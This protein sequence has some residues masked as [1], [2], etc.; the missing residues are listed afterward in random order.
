MRIGIHLE[1]ASGAPRR[2]PPPASRRSMRGEIQQDLAAFARVALGE[3]ERARD[4]AKIERVRDDVL[5]MHAPVGDP[6]DDLREHRAV[7][8]RRA[9]RQFLLRQLGLHDRRRLRREAEHTD[10]RGGRREPHRLLEDRRMADRVEDQR[11]AAVDAASL[12]RV[13]HRF[14]RRVDDFVGRRAALARER[15]TLV[16]A[17]GDERA[18]AVDVLEHLQQ[19]EA[20]GARAVDQ[21]DV[22]RQ[23]AGA[24]GRV[25][26]DRERLDDRSARVGDLGRN[27]VGVRGGHAGVLAEAAV[28]MH[29]E[30]G[31][32][33]AHVAPAD[34]ACV[35]APATDDRVDCDDLADAR[36]V[37]ARADRFDSPDELVPDDA[38]IRD[39]RVLA[40][41]DVQIRSADARI[42]HAHAHFARGGLGRGHFAHA[43][44]MRL[45]DDDAQHVLILLRVS[46]RRWGGARSPVPHRAVAQAGDG[47][48]GALVRIVR[49]ER[50][51]DVDAE[52]GHVVHHEIAVVEAIVVREHLVGQR[53]VRHQLLDAEVRRPQSEV[54]RGRHAHGRQVGR[55]VK[56]RADLVHRRVIGD[57]AHVRDAARVHDRRADVVDQLIAD[58]VL[59]IPDRIEDLADRERRRRVAADQ[60]ECVLVL[61]GRRVLEPEQPV[62]LEI[63]AEARRLDRREP[64]MRV[65][66]QVRRV[67]ERVAHLAEQLGRMAQV[68]RGVPRLLGR[69][70]FFGGLVRAR[71]LADAV[72]LRQPRHA[73]LHADRAVARGDVPVRGVDR[74]VVIA[75]VRVAIDHQPFAALA[76]EQLIDGHAGELALDVPERHVDRGDRRHRHGPAPPVR[77]AIQVLPDVLDVARVPADQARE[78]VILQIRAHRELAPVERRVAEAVDAFVGDDLDRHEIP[79]GAGDDDVQPFDFHAVSPVRGSVDKVVG[80]ALAHLGQV[81]VHAVDVHRDRCAEQRHVARRDVREDLLVLVQRAARVVFDAIEQQPA[82]AVE[83]PFHRLQHGPHVRAAG[84]FEHPAVHRL[85]EREERVDVVRGHRVALRVDE[86]GELRELRRRDLL[87]EIDVVRAFERAAREAA[88]L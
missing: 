37:D 12:E 52:A 64:V 39:E 9:Q 18:N 73:R 47:Q 20:D 82:H 15:E 58:Q 7:Q 42:A 79:A 4:I 71:R 32:A 14:R 27:P 10:A 69:Q 81:G 66:Q 36:R 86:A 49:G 34:R 77:A 83:L 50:L 5:R 38:R 1:A 72:H 62:R 29:A 31:Q 40:V 56:A 46:S 76:A 61:G 48:V 2:A 44:A 19:R 28:A 60:P 84:E 8:A 6:F 63:A 23:H 24:R 11:R 13:R 80:R 33:A 65:V 26:G 70:A 74:L 85:V 45:V 22:G 55:A 78:H 21:R 54:H 53:R 30:H 51:V 67:A 87:R 41:E 16:E 59:A 3:L 68:E 57:A 88:F 75:P 35:A 17:I 25:R 43:H